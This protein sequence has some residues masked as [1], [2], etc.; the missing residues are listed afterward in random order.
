MI[1]R[2]DLGEPVRAFLLLEEY[3][4]GAREHLLGRSQPDPRSREDSC[5]VG[6][7]LQDTPSVFRSCEALHLGK[8]NS[9]LLP[10]TSREGVHRRYRDSSAT[11]GSESLESRKPA[12]ILLSGFLFFAEEAPEERLALRL[13]EALPEL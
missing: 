9:V 8:Q 12:P 7:A 13:P 3:C 11:F 2:V 10:L 5:L 6:L 1:D 4:S